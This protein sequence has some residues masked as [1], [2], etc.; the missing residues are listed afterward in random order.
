MATSDLLMWCVFLTVHYFTITQSK[1]VTWNSSGPALERFLIDEDYDLI[2]VAEVNFF[3][4]L[5]LSNM[6]LNEVGFIN[7]T[8]SYT[9]LT[10]CE[11]NFYKPDYLCQYNNYALHLSTM[12]VTLNR[13]A[14]AAAGTFNTLDTFVTCSSN[15]SSPACHYRKRSDMTVLREVSGDHFAP[16]D[17]YNGTSSLLLS[18]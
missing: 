10:S 2:Y 5:S 7:N 17:I 8:P 9:V 16:Y 3:H 1:Y 18:K 6:S 4:A 12:N 14:G 15:Y 13:T 11:N